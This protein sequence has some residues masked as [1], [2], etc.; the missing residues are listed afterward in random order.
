M[1][2]VDQIKRVAVIGTG[3]I[4]FSW[5]LVFSRAGLATRV[6]DADPK[7]L[8]SLRDRVAIGL[9]AL[10]RA[11]RLTVGDLEA[12]S[13]RVSYCA[14]LASALEDADYVQESV[15]E[16]LSLKQEVFE[17]L[18]RRTPR[19]TI[20]GSSAS[21]LPMTEIAR[22]T[23]HPERCIV[24]H[25]TNPPHLVPL[26]EVVPGVKTDPEVTHATYAFMKRLG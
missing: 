1:R 23:R 10:R 12:A 8:D 9:A 24:A 19:A 22:Y 17:E 14:D 11:G 13:N 20:L 25:P 6:Y 26:V 18:D 21:A 2:G 5:T 4:G 16:S 15:P 7:Q 3:T